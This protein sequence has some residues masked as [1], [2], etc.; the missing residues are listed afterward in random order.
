MTRKIGIFVLCASFIFQA[1]H[2]KA[3]SDNFIIRALVGED[4][5][6]PSVPTGVS[7][8][9]IA[10]SQ[11]D[12]SWDPST[13]NVGVSGYQVYRD[14]FQI[15]TT[16]ST[17][18]SDT[19]L[20]PD[21]Y[22]TYYV[23]AFDAQ[24]NY[25]ASSSVVGT[26]TLPIAVP[27]TI[28]P[29]GNTSS[30]GGKY[31]ELTP[32]MPSLTFLQIFPATSSVLIRYE[33]KG[34]VRSIVGWGTSISYEIGSLA[35]Q[36]FTTVHEARIGNL[37]PN[38]LYKFRIQGENS[39][40]VFIDLTENTFKT[41]SLQD[42][43]PPGNVTGLTTHL[44]E[45]NVRLTWVNPNETDF[46]HVRIVESSTFYPGDPQDGRVVYEGNGVSFL[47][48]GRGLPGTTIY[49]T[50]FAYDTAGNVSSGSVV[51]IT[52]DE[53]G[54]EGSHSIPIQTDETGTPLN[55]LSFSWDDLT[56]SQEGTTL[57]SH[58][59]GAIHLD[60]TK[61]LVISLGYTTLPEHLKTI[62]V[63]IREAEMSENEFTFLLRV[64]STKTVYEAVIAPFGR[65][66]VMPTR[67]AIFDFETAEV[68][69]AEGVLVSKV[70]TSTNSETE[71]TFFS[72]FMNTMG[73]LSCLWLF[74]VLIV[75]VI[76]V[77]VWRYKK[78]TRTHAH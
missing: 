70:H 50:V 12:I 57:S 55:P 24:G 22:F 46:D 63:T 31:V 45:M 78:H 26:T 72:A 33:T 64:N 29:S 16:T 8:S 11:I 40:G 42:L 59:G 10:T 76:L 4:T 51:G 44:D 27:P 66:A 77:F 71:N 3:A 34:L 73:N 67:V 75:L 30:S 19:S 65:T 69:Y 20:T 61:A 56:F 17:S 47:D 13:D 38:T 68:G 62:L 15:G 41:L 25:S 53:K 2:V 7:V 37:N 14:A 54:E 48:K 74:L 5:M 39:S 21:T 23:R 6:A 43:Y 35:E 28:P 58:E 32:G 9:P 36:T 18:Y 52:I 49:Y 1:H 60:G